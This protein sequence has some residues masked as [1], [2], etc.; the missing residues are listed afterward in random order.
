[1]L[2][3]HKQYTA[4]AQAYSSRLHSNLLFLRQ[5][6][7]SS[8]PIRVLAWLQAQNLRC[9][10][11]VGNTRAE[12]VQD[13]ARCALLEFLE[14]QR[15]CDPREFLDHVARATRVRAFSWCLRDSLWE[16]S[17]NLARCAFA[18]SLQSHWSITTIRGSTLRERLT[19]SMCCWTTMWK[20]MPAKTRKVRR[21]HRGSAVVGQPV[22]YRS[23][24]N[25]LT[26]RTVH[27]KHYSWRI[28]LST[29]VPA[30]SVAAP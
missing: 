9:G 22:D 2:I 17:S 10:A 18:N 3:Y 21:K 29:F 16:C 13:A 28:S 12:A 15:A 24:Q 5:K 14:V 4:A 8:Q 20:A 19:I 7:G 30:S 23:E 1:M 6:D 26:F 11:G 25:F 27:E